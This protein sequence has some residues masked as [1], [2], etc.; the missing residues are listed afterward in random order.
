PWP[1]NDVYNAVQFILQGSG[2]VIRVENTL[3][4]SSTAPTSSPSL[5][6]KAEDISQLLNEISSLKLA[7]ES[8]KA[9]QGS[10]SSTLEAEIFALKS[11]NA[12][13]PQT[14]GI[15]CTSAQASKTASISKTSPSA[16]QVQP[17]TTPERPF[18]ASRATSVAH[19][20]PIQPSDPAPTLDKQSD[21]AYPH[22]PSI[23]DPKL[24]S[25]VA[26]KFVDIPI[27][28]TAQEHLAVAPDLRSHVC[29]SIITQQ[30]ATKE[31][32]IISVA[33]DKDYSLE[34]HEEVV[35]STILLNQE[36]SDPPQ[37]PSASHSHPV[38][39]FSVNVA[40]DA[41]ETCLPSLPRGQTRTPDPD[42][43]A[44][45]SASPE[46]DILLG[47]PFEVIPDAFVQDSRNSSQVMTLSDP[48]TGQAVTTVPTKPR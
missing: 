34:E 32:A 13:R 11:Q 41:I 17:E 1:I 38:S 46:D 47:R 24:T 8:L 44:V 45:A 20:D 14:Q 10:R 31:S 28:M 21:P 30:I 36:F 39:V 3:P 4:V 26:D 9:N 42:R 35:S 40:P 33:Q 43:L 6:F 2:N 23:C 48:D 29:E 12:H 18:R 16:A 15:I 22:S 5:P 37:P 27:T 25:C 19:N 7:V